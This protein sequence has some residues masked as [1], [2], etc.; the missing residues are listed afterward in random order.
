MYVD[1]VRSDHRI[2]APARWLGRSVAVVAVAAAASTLLVPDVLS[3]AAVMNGSARGTAIAVLF[4][5]VPVLVIGMMLEQRGH[6]AGYP[7]WLGSAAFLAYNG[8][9][10]LFATPFNQLFLVYVALLAGAV[11]SIAS[12]LPDA[13][14]RRVGADQVP[15]R[16]V[17]TYLLVITILN[18][19]LWLRNVVPAMLADR[20]T[21]LVDGTGL[22]TNPVYVQ[23]LVF[24][25]PMVAVV[26]VWLW[27][28]RDVGVVLAA[29]VLVFWEIEAICVAL[30]QWL[31]HR[32]DPS[33]AVASAGAVPLF[34]GLFLVGTVPSRLVLRAF[35]RSEVDR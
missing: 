21:E 31:G 25:L 11:W 35:R 28:R 2:G 19:L 14:Q 1:R 27:Q 26:A 30:D 13:E 4:V 23:D 12:L 9:L 32:A 17:A 6:P 33:S 22:T 16:A 18:I 20:P 34:L 24:W 7:L 15:A 29:A 10:F 8:V 5:G 3:G